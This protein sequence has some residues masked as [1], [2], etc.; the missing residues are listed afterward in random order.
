MTKRRPVP[1]NRIPKTQSQWRPRLPITPF[2]PIL[3]LAPPGQHWTPPPLFSLVLQQQHCVPFVR[4]QQNPPSLLS[5]CPPL[6]CFVSFNSTSEAFNE[7][8]KWCRG[9]HLCYERNTRPTGKT[10]ESFWRVAACCWRKC[11]L[12]TVETTQKICAYKVP[13]DYSMQEGRSPRNILTRQAE[14][15]GKASQH[16][17]CPHNRPGL[18]LLPFCWRGGSLG[19]KFPRWQRKST[20]L[21]LQRHLCIYNRSGWL[22]VLDKAKLVSLLQEGL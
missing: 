15:L 8:C 18:G 20:V 2:L 11:L 17:V 10:G 16:S 19:A 4:Q 9:T 5:L 1:N 14:T 21:P 12:R 22:P 6:W 3:E 13:D 7:S